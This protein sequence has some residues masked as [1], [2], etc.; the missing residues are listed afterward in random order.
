LTRID[1]HSISIQFCNEHNRCW[2]VTCVYG[3]QSNSDKMLFLQEL[4]DIRAACFGPWLIAGDFNLIYRASD[5]NNSNLD[6]AMMGRF[7][8]LIEDLS[9]KEIPLYRR[10]YMGSNQQDSHVLVKLDRVLCSVEWEE[11]FHNVLQSAA[12]EGSDHCP[13]CLA[14]ET[15]K[16]VKDD[17][18]LKPFGPSWRDSIMLSRRFGNLWQL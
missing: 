11:I 10:K 8:K 12:S 2:W 18:V 13:C 1:R 14:L 4:R 16:W 15:T 3:P 5:K 6:R 7:R 9:L 17:S